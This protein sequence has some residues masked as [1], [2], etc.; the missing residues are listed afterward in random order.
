MTSFFF[1]KKKI[2]NVLIETFNPKVDG[3]YI[4]SL[5]PKLSG[6]F[7]WIYCE[8][9]DIQNSTRFIDYMTYKRQKK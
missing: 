8:Y 6:S 3:N 2:L 4:S 5:F 1:K 9:V 7:F